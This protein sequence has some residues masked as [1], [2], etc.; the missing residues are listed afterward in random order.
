MAAG[1]D[2][3]V[4]AVEAAGVCPNVWGARRGSG[5]AGGSSNDDCRPG[6]E[7]RI[8]SSRGCSCC[9]REGVSISSPN[10]IRR[11]FVRSVVVVPKRSS[12]SE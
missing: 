11:L 4:V 9:G 3:F 6:E 10:E 7:V 1:V 2:G 8:I 12:N 5:V